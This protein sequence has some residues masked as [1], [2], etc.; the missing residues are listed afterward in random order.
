MALLKEKREAWHVP[1]MGATPQKVTVTLTDNGGKPYVIWHIDGEGTRNVAYV[2]FGYCIFATEAEAW[3]ASVDRYRQFVNEEREKLHHR[4]AR[5]A[6]M[7]QMLHI[8]E[9]E[10]R[11]KTEASSV[12]SD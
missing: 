10:S 2:S 3:Q 5:L 4:E 11:G 9:K 6:T 12:A 8:L 7:M 1:Y